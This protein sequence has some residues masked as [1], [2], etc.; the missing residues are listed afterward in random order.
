M[1]NTSTILLTS[2]NYFQWKS[3]MENLLRS[4]GFYRITLGTKIASTDDEAKVVKWDNKN[5]QAHGL[6]GMSISLDLKFHLDGLD[7]PVEAWEK[8]TNVF[9]LKNEIQT[10]QLENKVLT[11]DLSNITFI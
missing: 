2:T 8:L 7:S 3:H 10:Y 6:I 1:E 11:L 4:K 5:D 9:V